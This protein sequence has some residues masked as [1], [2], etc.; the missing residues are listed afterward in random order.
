MQ[1]AARAGPA[2]S[3]AGGAQPY[4]RERRT[5]FGIFSSSFLLGFSGALQAG[6][7]IAVRRAGVVARSL[8]SH[9][10]IYAAI[11]AQD[12]ERAR[13]AMRRHILQCEEDVR[14]GLRAGAPG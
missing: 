6:R 13:E 1:T 3:D 4:G 7:F 11:R 9:R 2:L 14:A 12:A 5:L 8:S 10:T